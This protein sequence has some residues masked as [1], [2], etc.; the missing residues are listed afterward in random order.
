[1]TATVS[2]HAVWKQPRQSRSLTLDVWQVSGPYLQFRGLVA[3][4][5]SP[6]GA[7]ALVPVGCSIHDASPH[8]QQDNSDSIA[9]QLF[10][11]SRFGKQVSLREYI[12]RMPADQH[13]IYY[14]LT[15][16][17]M[18]LWPSMDTLALFPIYNGF[19]IVF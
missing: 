11:T 19:E 6:L 4:L 16:D 7:A 10:R 9:H 14:L 3:H 2:I 13:D 12:D 5:V 8:P 15:T 18:A 17:P 1:M